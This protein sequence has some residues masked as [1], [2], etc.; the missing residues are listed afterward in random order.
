MSLPGI[1]SSQRLQALLLKGNSSGVLAELNTYFS[2]PII[3]SVD[4]TD[5]SNNKKP[6]KPRLPQHLPFR[7]L[8]YVMN[9]TPNPV[10]LLLGVAN[11]A[12]SDPYSVDTKRKIFM[13]LGGTIARIYA[14]VDPTLAPAAPYFRQTMGKSLGSLQSP[15]KLSKSPLQKPDKADSSS[16]TSRS[17]SSDTS[18]AEDLDDSESFDR[19]ADISKWIHSDYLSNWNDFCT[20]QIS[21]RRQHTQTT[22][23]L[24]QNSSTSPF[25]HWLAEPFSIQFLPPKTTQEDHSDQTPAQI[26][27]G[28]YQASLSFY[29]VN[30]ILENLM[31]QHAMADYVKIVCDNQLCRFVDLE[32]AFTI[33]LEK[34]NTQLLAELVKKT[35]WTRYTLYEM[36]EK[37]WY[38]CIVSLSNPSYSTKERS[39]SCRKVMNI[40]DSSDAVHF[41]AISFS[42]RYAALNWSIMSVKDIITQQNMDPNHSYTDLT[43]CLVDILETLMRTINTHALDHPP[44]LDNQ[45]APYKYLKQRVSADQ[46]IEFTLNHIFHS[47]HKDSALCG[48]IKNRFST[49]IP[50][51]ILDAAYHVN[52]SRGGNKSH[53]SRPSFSNSGMQIPFYTTD[54]PICFVN[55]KEKLE[56]FKTKI[57][58]IVDIGIDAEW[59]NQGS[60]R[61]S[62]FQI[63][64]L[65]NDTSRRVYI[66]DLFNLD[67]TETCNVLTALFSSKRITTLGFDGVQDLK[68]LNALMPTLPLPYNLVDLNKLSMELFADKLKRHD[69][70]KQ[71]LGLSDLVLVVLDKTLDKRVRLTDWNRRPL[72]QCQLTYAASDSDVL[73]DIYKKWKAVQ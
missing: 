56:Y 44:R 67:L 4:I 11:A 66:L 42:E 57:P 73:I 64:V 50:H 62:I 20:R 31:R 43:E 52:C 41:S 70:K 39:K 51:D 33:L 22:L 35:P 60:D 40:V 5:E 6:L 23:K 21:L 45:S 61:M 19:P 32:S 16:I 34:T 69:I 54:T 29:H 65:L 25:V 58:D 8:K 10:G 1:Y 2:V 48:M 71:Q 3:A 27:T 12:V 68:K 47:F 13:G 30:R 53:T 49:F 28:Q 14:A 38:N 72:R 9:A 26:A 18:D 15:V 46:M 37:E 59:Y 63:A 24:L 36:V 7:F 17:T 55:T